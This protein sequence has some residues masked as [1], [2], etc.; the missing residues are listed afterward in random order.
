MALLDFL[1]GKRDKLK[2]IPTMAPFQQ[3]ALQGL[4]QNPLQNNPLY[5]Q[6]S[7]Y[8]QQL[9]SGSPESFANFEAPY[10]QNF[11]QNIVPQLAERFAGS[12]TGSGA[13]SSSGFQNSLGQA[14]RNLQTD[15]AGL[16]SGLQA[17]AL[18]QAL[19]YAQQPYSNA[20]AGSQIPSFSYLNQRGQQGL[21]PGI[22]NTLGMGFGMGPLTNYFNSYFG[23]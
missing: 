3:Q 20:I 13:L 10:M 14:G 18:P 19:G 23:L 11:Q 5:Q 2:Q 4:F 9:L 7:S 16:R 22:G 12:G 17:G 1:F 6:G 8:L 21:I 15:L